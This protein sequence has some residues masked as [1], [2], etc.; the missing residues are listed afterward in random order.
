MGVKDTSWRWAVWGGGRQRGKDNKNN[1]KEEKLPLEFNS[2]DLF[3]SSFGR[4]A[5]VHICNVFF[6][7][8]STPP[9]N[10]VLLESVSYASKSYDI[11][12]IA[13]QTLSEKLYMCV[14]CSCIP[15]KVVSPDLA[16]EL[17]S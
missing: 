5:M 10:L 7:C 15:E 17:L 4:R 12:G 8:H 11:L 9:K 2:R 16:E 6:R 3:Q 13:S 14:E 1:Q